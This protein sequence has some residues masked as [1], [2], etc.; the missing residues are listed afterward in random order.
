MHLMTFCLHSLCLLSFCLSSDCFLA[1]GLSSGCL[2]IRFSHDCL[3]S[4]CV[5]STPRL[6]VEHVLQCKPAIPVNDE[7]LVLVDDVPVFFYVC[8]GLTCNNDMFSVLFLVLLWAFIGPF[9]SVGMIGILAIERSAGSG[10][11]VQ[12]WRLLFLVIAEATC[13]HLGAIGGCQIQAVGPPF[14]SKYLLLQVADGLDGGV[15]CICHGVYRVIFVPCV[16]T[17]ARGQEMHE[18]G[19]DV[20]AVSAALDVGICVIVQQVANSTSD[21]G[22]VRD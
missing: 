16:C 17:F 11:K 14:G 9:V 10:R 6:R 15:E 5:V 18:Q 8:A 4:I 7:V 20:L 12:A 19:T 3:V 2:L 22:E 13:D 21:R 1:F